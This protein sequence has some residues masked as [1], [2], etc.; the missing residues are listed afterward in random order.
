MKKIVLILLISF[1]C[2]SF[3]VFNHYPIDGYERTGI[4]RLKR[5]EMIKSGE[6]KD[7]TLLPAGA[8]KGYMDIQLNLISKKSDSISTFF[9]KN[10]NFQNVISGLFKGLD[11]SYSLAILDISDPDNLRYASRNETLGYQPGSVGKLA[12][13]IALFNE[14]QRIYP[15]DFEKRLDVLRNRSVK[16]GLWG[17]TDEHTVPIF[18]IETKKLVKRQVIASDVFTVFEWADHMMSVSNNGAA[19]IVWRE[20]LLMSVFGKD[21]AT[22]TQEAADAYFKNT[23]KAEITNLANDVVNLPL[24][25]IGIGPDEWRLGSFFTRGSNN[26]VGSKGGSIGSP[27]GL[28]K[29][30]VQLEQGNVVDEASS[31][32]MKRLMYM[33]DRRIR[34]AQAPILKEAA[35][36]FKSGSLYKCDRSKGEACGKYMGN[37]SNFMN[38]VAIIEHPDNCRYIIVLMT[39]VLRKN[40]ASDHMYLATSIDKAIRNN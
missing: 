3:T 40:S 27:L 29:F 16:A 18:N 4:K 14:L 7:G 24:R 35:V 1:V 34:Y 21:Y 32:E 31:L 11:R 19:S 10:E 15:D 9:Q 6:I 25:K 12:V 28:M 17:L 39:N 8:Y 22:L 38:S 36:Y 2:A 13:L 26:Y 30:L 37:V 5:L 23:P 33:T 20:A